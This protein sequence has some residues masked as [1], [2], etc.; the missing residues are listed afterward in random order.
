MNSLS[1]YQVGLV[2]MNHLRRWWRVSWS[3]HNRKSV[4][5]SPRF[6]SSTAWENHRFSMTSR[7]SPRF[8]KRS[9]RLRTRSIYSRSFADRY[10]TPSKWVNSSCRRTWK[11]YSAT[12]YNNNHSPTQQY[13]FSSFKTKRQQLCGKRWS[14]NRLARACK[15]LTITLKLPKVQSG[16][17]F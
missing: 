13:S 10:A 2:S 6:S 3:N 9:C 5:W 8:R 12:N 14:K 7:S 4:R 1:S 11:N 17:V 16:F 15:E